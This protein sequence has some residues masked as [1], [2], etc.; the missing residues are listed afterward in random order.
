MVAT[1]AYPFLSFGDSIYMRR[2][3]YKIEQE[4]FG[5]RWLGEGKGGSLAG[6]GYGVSSFAGRE[7]KFDG[8]YPGHMERRSI[9]LPVRL[10]KMENKK[11]TTLR[12]CWLGS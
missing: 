6:V 2:W 1:A 3:D 8:Q 4:H 5:E 11:Y 9:G 12:L 10:A 7:T